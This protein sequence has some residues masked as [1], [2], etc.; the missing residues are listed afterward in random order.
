MA[1]ADMAYWATAG[2]AGLALAV[3]AWAWRFTGRARARLDG[4]AHAVEAEKRKGD[5]WRAA[6]AA[7]GI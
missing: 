2:A 7:G 3:G 6:F 1:D 4:L 5:L